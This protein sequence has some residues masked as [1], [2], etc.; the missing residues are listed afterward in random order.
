[1]S[2]GHGEKGHEALKKKEQST[3]FQSW[4]T[5]REALRKGQ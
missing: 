1:M 2:K 4:R 3:G 5:P